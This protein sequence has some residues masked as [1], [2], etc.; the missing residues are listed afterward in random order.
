MNSLVLLAVLATAPSAV[1]GA[2]EADLK[3]RVQTGTLIFS[4]G[5]C[6]AIQ[7]FSGSPYT[8]VGAVVVEQGRATVYDAMN[9]AGVRK[10]SLAEYVQ[11]LTPSTVWVLQPM[12]P[13]TSAEASAFVRH[14]E[15]QLGRPYRIRH[16]STGRRCEGLH[17]AEYVTDALMAA[18][19]F[20]AREPARVSPG[21]L[22][23]GVRQS[24]RY[25]PG[26]QYELAEPKAAS[27][28]RDETWCQW[29]WRETKECCTACCRQM[30]RWFLC[31]SK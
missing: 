25:A 11:F 17:C 21:S 28:P 18:G 22:W 23:Q 2:V 1:H 31:R 20:T 3:D 19:W 10:Q 14:L 9:G 16:Y 6:L 30:A 12:Q 8:H 4:Q 13:M 26:P 29:S 24:E 15:S 5:D 27:P 7:V